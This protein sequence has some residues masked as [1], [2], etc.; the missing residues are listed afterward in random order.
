MKID[1]VAT[2]HYTAYGQ[3][4]TNK[5]PT[6]GWEYCYIEQE[7]ASSFDA[8]K[9]AAVLKRGGCKNVAVRRVTEW[10]GHHVIRTVV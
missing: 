5:L 8:Q 4:R 3:F 1:A 9:A 7:Y 10:S 6:G 2:I